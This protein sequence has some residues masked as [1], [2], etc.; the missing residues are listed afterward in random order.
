MDKRRLQKYF[1]FT[2]NDLEANCRNEFSAGQKKRLSFE[3][4][5]EQKSSRDSAVIL[6]VIALLGMALGFTLGFI[7]PVGFGRILLFLAMG[8]LWPAAWAGKGIQIIRD[9]RVLG[10]PVLRSV[11]GRVQPKRLSS[12]DFILQ[13]GDIEFD[14][15]GNPSGV[16]MDG[17]DLT[18]YYLEATQEILSVVYSTG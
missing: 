4:R 2:E 10:E 16:I 7:A 15:E 3:A 9:A 14:L 13:V 1:M 5:A 8:F 6:F 17:D 12:E 11:S 18:I